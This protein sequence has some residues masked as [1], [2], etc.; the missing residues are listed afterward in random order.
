M[1]GI[2][3]LHHDIMF[4]LI[5]TVFFV[6]WMLCRIIFLFGVKK[7]PIPSNITHNTELELA[8]TTVPSL[9]L[10]FLAV[11]SFSLLYAIDELIAP[12]LTIKVVGNQWFWNYEYSDLIKDIN[13]D[14]YMILEEDLIIG[15]IRLLEVDN[16]LVLP[17]ELSIR[18]LIT[19]NDV[20]HS[21]SIPSLGVK[22]DACPGRLNQI[23]LWINRPGVYYG[24]CSEICGLNH[25]F[26]PIVVEA[27]KLN[28]FLAYIRDA[29]DVGLKWYDTTC[30]DLLDN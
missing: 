29:G 24:Q 16:R 10:L 22:M 6:L 4:F 2:I 7:N 5:L 25:G 8:W 23:S 18:I 19:S 17:V 9:L 12:D 13:F 27:V 1:E 30:I 14:S 28:S 3:D 20:L 11:P 26:M 21:F 15:S